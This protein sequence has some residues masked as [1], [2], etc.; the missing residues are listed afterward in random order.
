MCSFEDKF[1][2]DAEG[3]PRIWRPSDDIEGTYTA[4]RA[5][6]MTLI[7][8]LSHFRL[9][10]T[11]ASP[12]LDA[13]IGRAPSSMSA[14]DDE[15]LPPIGGVDDEDGKTLG[16]EMTVLSE[17]KA[18]DLSA[19]FK[20]TADGV[21]VEAKRSA[22]GGV[23]QVPVYFYLILLALGWNEI[24]AVLRNPLYFAFL[25]VLAAGGYVTYTLNLWG[26]LLRM[27]D[28]A[29]SQ[30]IEVGKER[31]RDF[32]EAQ[33]EGPAATRRPMRMSAGGGAED[34]VVGRPDRPDATSGGAD[35]GEL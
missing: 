35:D 17:A 34:K 18:A 13:W 11:S 30:A 16:E 6:T 28:A 7:P 23:T 26:P 5:S 25:A 33:N 4:A 20:K 9:S 14:A 12:P 21:Y 3:V 29:T 24:V 1:R 19:R 27:A 2:Y 22:I 15:D 10:S 8:L 32:L 31:L